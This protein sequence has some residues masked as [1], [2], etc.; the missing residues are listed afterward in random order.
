[1]KSAFIDVRPELHA[2]QKGY[3]GHSDIRPWAMGMCNIVIG[4]WDKMVSA[5]VQIISGRK[6]GTAGPAGGK[7]LVPRHRSSAQPAGLAK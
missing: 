4:S 6:Q 7:A 3:T 1:M 2:E 5:Q